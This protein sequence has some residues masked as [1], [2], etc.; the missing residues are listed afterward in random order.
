[1]TRKKRG[2][3]PPQQ[4]ARHRL[5]GLDVRPL[6]LSKRFLQDRHAALKRAQPIQRVAEARHRALR[7]R[8]QRLETLLCLG[9]LAESFEALSDDGAIGPKTV[10][11]AGALEHVPALDQGLLGADAAGA[12]LGQGVAIV[13]QLLERGLAAA[14]GRF[15]SGHGLFRDLEAAGV[16][17]TAGFQ[18]SDR[19]FETG[20]GPR[21]ALVAAADA[22]LQPVP[23]RAFV[24]VQVVEL[25]M[26]DR[27]GGAEETLVGD[28][29]QLGDD[30]IGPSRVGVGL[31]VVFEGHLAALAPELLLQHAMADGQLA[32]FLVVVLDHELQTRARM[33]LVGG[34]PRM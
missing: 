23:Q 15:R 3:Q 33:G 22:A 1:M 5:I 29:R 24:A 8:L 16:L 19:L 21:A 27:G 20:L 28:A 10:R 2:R 11:L 9:G 6:L 7:H 4:V 12:S 30:L 32:G 31:A 13:F 34:A 14:E 26:A 25:L 17:V 18:S